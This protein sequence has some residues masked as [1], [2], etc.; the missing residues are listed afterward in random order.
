MKIKYHFRLIV[1][2]FSIL[3]SGHLPAQNPS[4][5]P[6]STEELPLPSVADPIQAQSGEG[7]GVQVQYAPALDG[8]GLI[9]LDRTRK[10]RM[11]LGGSFTTGWDSN[12]RNEKKGYPSGLLALSPFL[13]IQGST[14]RRQF[15]LQYAP[16]FVSNYGSNVSSSQ[17]LNRASAQMAGILSERWQLKFD[18]DA[19]YGQDS[20]RLL[21]PPQGV[22]VGEIPGI[23]PNAAAYRRDAGK[24]TAIEGGMEVQY[25]KSARDLVALQVG[26]SYTHFSGLG[27]NN[28]VATTRLSYDR[29]LSP[30]FGL[31]A[32]GDIYY[33]YGSVN[34]TSLGGGI[35][36]KWMV[37][38]RTSLQMGGGPQV[39][40]AACGN[41]MGFA[42]NTAFSTRLS[43][44][45]QLYALASRQFGTNYLGP[46][47]WQDNVSAGYQRQVGSAGA[48]GL[49]LG[50]SHSAA[51]ATAGSYNGVYFEG[52]F[53]RQ[54]GHQC[55]STVTYRRYSGNT[56]GG[57]FSRDV[58]MFLLSWTPNTGHIFK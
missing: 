33:D 51:R 2:S 9:A 38:E 30:T 25:A 12:Q 18:A 17:T 56:G 1:V 5:D 49:D 43:A 36:A 47:L 15:L 31:G 45:S 53:N 23:G 19:S 55:F 54:L 6:S 8:S 50:Y 28:S 58:A 13:G 27:G 14:G 41:Q 26:D 29:R 37:R 3:I 35:E 21:V 16:T 10:S 48:L 20:L 22:V 42:F 24:V 32:Y 52:S 7:E 57:S 34:C 4:G 44:K 11:L 39:N 46:G 40:S